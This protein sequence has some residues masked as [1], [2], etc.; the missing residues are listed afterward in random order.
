[1]RTD[2]GVKGN[3]VNDLLCVQAFH[4]R[5]GVEFVEKADAQSQISIGK[6]FNGFRFGKAHDQCLHVF[7]ESA[8]LQQFRELARRIDEP[9]I[10]KVGADDDPRRIKVV[11]ERPAFPQEFG[12]ENDVAASGFLPN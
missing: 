1:M 11:V 5:I 8:F 3:A 2:S 4:F 6:K 7:F 9:R 10:V 12:A